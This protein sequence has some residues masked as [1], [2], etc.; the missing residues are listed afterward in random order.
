M[1]TLWNKI[2]R[3]FIKHRLQPIRVL[4]FHQASA[5][6][7]TSNSWECDWMHTDVFKQKILQL[8]KEGYTFI[9]LS[10]AYEKLKNDKSR[11][12]KYA[13]LTEDDAN[14]C[15]LDLMPW[16]ADQNIP[17]TLFIPF[18]FVTREN[19]THRCGVSMTEEQLKEL[20]NQYPSLI[21]IG[22][23]GYNHTEVIR[24][25]I[26]NFLTDVDAAENHL[27]TYPEKIPFFAY[28]GGRHTPVSDM[29]LHKAGL[30]PV[31]CD[32]NINYNN[33]DV[34]HRELL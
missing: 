20:L 27:A 5:Q 23:H 25:T 28:P 16:L 2:V 13:V 30:I 10:E 33:V 1:K 17:I 31:Y 3:K 19:S 22:N 21:T 29:L 26:D 6:L 8:K 18:A 12:E 32:G 24:M 4:C 7:D 15:I 34:I 14:S 9:S 11:K